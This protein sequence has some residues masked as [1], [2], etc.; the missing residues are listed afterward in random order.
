[1]IKSR[2]YF[3]WVTT[4][5]FNEKTTR[6][7]V[8]VHLVDVYTPAKT[9]IE[10]R[11]RAYSGSRDG[12]YYD[13]GIE[14]EALVQLQGALAKNKAMAG[15]IM[16]FHVWQNGKWVQAMTKMHS[17]LAR[18]MYI[19]VKDVVDVALH[20]HGDSEAEEEELA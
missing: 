15:V 5:H 3:P 18:K 19:K 9:S 16:V 11:E 6:M 14:D 20:Q 1:M 17:L 2:T 7:V 12:F 10:I 4:V 13:Y 8:N